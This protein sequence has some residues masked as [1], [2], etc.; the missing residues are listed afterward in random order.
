MDTREGSRSWRVPGGAPVTVFRPW[1]EA[2]IAFEDSVQIVDWVS[3]DGEGVQLAELN[4]MILAPSIP[5]HN[6]EQSVSGA[7]TVTDMLH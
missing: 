2:S 4:R 7:L 6:I 3:G 1:K 5:A